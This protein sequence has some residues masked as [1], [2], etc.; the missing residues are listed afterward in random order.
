MTEVLRASPD[1]D[2]EPPAGAATVGQ[3]STGLTMTRSHDAS[4]W[5]KDGPVYHI[6][7][8]SFRDATGD[9][10]GD[11]RGIIE[12]LDYLNDGTDR[13]LGVKG[14]WLSPIYLSPGRD[15]GYDVA[16]HLAIDPIFGDSDDFDELVA[17]CRRRGI[18]VILDLV[19][20]HTSDLHAWFLESR[21]SRDNP[22]RDWYVWREPGARGRPP[23]NWRSFFGGSAWT[24]DDDT[25][26]YYLHTF[27]PEQPDLNWHNP[28]VREAALDV[29]RHWLERGVSG[30][31]LD[32]FNA[33][34]K[35]PELPNNPGRLWPRR[36]RRPVYH[37]DR[38]ELHE[39][40]LELRG[41]LDRFPETMAVGEPFE[42]EPE[43]VAS[44][45][46]KLHMTFNFDFLR[47]PWDPGAVQRAIARWDRL[48]AAEGRWPCYVLS[49]HDNPR[50]AWRYGHETGG[51][52]AD[53][54][55]K[56]AAALLLTLRGTPFIYYGEEIGMQ[57]VIVPGDEMRDLAFD[58]VTRDT[59]RTPMHWD[60][61]A[62]AG[63]SVRR[64]W[65][66][67]GSDY[68]ER[69]VAAQEGDE[70]SI[71]NF[72]RRL[73]ALRE[74]TPALRLGAWQPLVRKPESAL[75]YIRTYGREYALV[76]L[77]FTE[78]RTRLGFDEELPLRRWTPRV[79]TR[80]SDLGWSVH[81][82]QRLELGPYE[83]TVF[84]GDAPTTNG[85]GPR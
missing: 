5:W 68:G 12:K 35:H 77:N 32:A 73:I 72:Y 34:F 81:L 51:K 54:R 61:S 63:F 84:T 58:A 21:S 56:V 13:S 28:E 14:I 6:Y 69:N 29:V 75:V 60:G 65:L 20:N 44:Y 85:D 37:R 80:R 2:G 83:A 70:R 71:L 79:S 11:L 24:Y 57:D 10:V 59:S 78:Q 25:G 52:V 46:D 16:D 40:L 30:F 64:P 7:P 22:R 26:E 48:L 19:V 55:A 31:R 9:G 49:N 15:V 62:N 39:F 66:A 50:H 74:Q 47:Q 45:S 33:Y 23:N 36:S 43:D 76:A 41:L 8:R 4:V 18:H 53:A 38:P 27:L 42:G 17:E 67:I 1:Y 82:G 3:L